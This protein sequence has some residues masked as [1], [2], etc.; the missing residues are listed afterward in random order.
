MFLCIFNKPCRVES[1]IGPHAY[2]HLFPIRWPE[3]SES[4]RVGRLGFAEALDV[5]AASTEGCRSPGSDPQGRSVLR[6]SCVHGLMLEVEKHHF[7]LDAH[8][9]DPAVAGLFQRIEGLRKEFLAQHLEV[10]DEMEV[11]D[12]SMF[13]RPPKLLRLSPTVEIPGPQ[14]PRACW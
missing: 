5:L 4:S 6:K 1:I 2:M 9:Q 13:Q 14:S 3:R 7:I 8:G 10:D 12:G 11:E